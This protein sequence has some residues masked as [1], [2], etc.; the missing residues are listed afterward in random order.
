MWSHFVRW[1][2]REEP[3]TP[4]ALARIGLGATSAVMLLDVVRRGLV[5]ALWVDSQYGGIRDL[6]DG[7]WLVSLLGGTNPTTMHGLVWAAIASSTAL[8]LGLGGRVTALAALLTVSSVVDVNGQAGG[9]YDELLENALWLLVLGPSTATLSVDC[10]LRTGR[11]TDDTPR[12]AGAR[13]LLLF[14]L[15]LMYWT[16]G[17]Q[18]VSYHWMPGGPFDAL[19]FIF[20]QPTWQRFDM[21]WVAWFYPL[22]QVGTGASWVW[23]V[24]SPLWLLA[25][26]Y[27]LTRTRSGWLRA[28]S[29]SVDLR[30]IYA[31]IGVVFHG[32][33]FVFMNVGPFSPVSLAYYFAVFDHEEYASAWQ[34]ISGR[35]RTGTTTAAH[36]AGP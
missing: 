23:E 3:A 31:L 17:L 4:L 13:Y 19:Y 10:R 9:S 34:R 35:G 16:T 25:F 32:A 14:Q 18:K 28:W 33:L 2:S 11:W 1:V 20:Q 7:N 26:W 21:R 8:T 24:S 5:D 30:V 27:R 12:W 15:V 29:N 6:G 36:P 22:T